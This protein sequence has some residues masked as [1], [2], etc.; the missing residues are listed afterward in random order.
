M[1]FAV[2]V[3]NPGS[4]STK[5][6][7]WS[8]E[9]PLLQKTVTHPA[10][11]LAK[12]PRVADQFDLRL[13]A[14]QE[15][16]AEWL[17]G[18]KLSAVVGR[19]GPL[20]PL[21]GGTYF[22]TDRMLEELRAA[23]WSNHA[24]NLGAIIAHYLA[25]RLDI[26]CFVVDP[27]TVDEFTPLARVSGLPEIPRKC[28][29]HALNLKATA[30][31]AAAQIGKPLDQTRFVVAHM[32]GGLSIAALDGGRIA[33]VN[34]GLLGMGPFSPERAGALPIG[35]LVKLSYSGKHTEEQLL[36]RLS[37][38]AGL[39][40]YLG[41]SDC[42]EVERRIA[43]GDSEARLYYDAMLYQ[44]AK[45]IGA[46]AAVL[47]GRLDGVILTGGMANSDYLVETLKAYVA[48]LGRIFV[49][50]GEKELEALAQGAFRVLLGQEEA[51]AY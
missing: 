48:F 39:K 17:D 12:Y 35:A 9:G 38:E 5:V 28:R 27:V 16:V 2:L 36:R 15:A 4:T 21:E 26:P 18:R 13:G 25:G 41:T 50:P 3:I 7:V 46:A 44:I 24:S 22:I 29:S 6:G 51:K 40:A 1:N 10:E 23:R 37:T 14:I 32:G 19:G 11:E 34:D 31:L 47:Q 20:R 49:I 42:V 30:R 33:D 8:P 43:G 45:E